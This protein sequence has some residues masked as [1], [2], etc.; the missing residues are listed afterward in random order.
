M[1]TRNT[2]TSAH[3]DDDTLKRCPENPWKFICSNFRLTFVVL[4]LIS[5]LWELPLLLEASSWARRLRCQTNKAANTCPNFVRLMLSLCGNNSLRRVVTLITSFFLLYYQF[6]LIVCC[7]AH[8]RT[9]SFRC[10]QTHGWDLIVTLSLNTYVMY[11]SLL[12]LLT[13]QSSSELE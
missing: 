4:N 12:I 6:P 10:F 1:E 13:I 11:I 8:L 9:L 3:L 7:Y 5:W 2:P